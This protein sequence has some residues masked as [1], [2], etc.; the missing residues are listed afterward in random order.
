VA[1]V[2]TGRALAARPRADGL[3]VA[4]VPLSRWA[5]DRGRGRPDAG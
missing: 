1:T 3:L 4:L 5:E 2:R